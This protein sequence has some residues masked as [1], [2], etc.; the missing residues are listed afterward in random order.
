MKLGPG[1][2]VYVRYYFFQL[3]KG[4]GSKNSTFLTVLEFPPRPSLR[5]AEWFSDAAASER[6]AARRVPV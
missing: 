2:T 1:T 6:A 3:V 4:N 5:R